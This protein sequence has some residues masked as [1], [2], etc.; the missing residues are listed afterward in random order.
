MLK[1]LSLTTTQIS[2]IRGLVKDKLSHYKKEHEHYLQLLKNGAWVMDRNPKQ[3]RK[4]IQYF[5]NRIKKL[6]KTNKK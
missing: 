5:K 2:E 1:D 6:S 4:K 3:Y